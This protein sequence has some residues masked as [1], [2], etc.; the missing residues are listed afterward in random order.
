MEVEV[1]LVR[2]LKPD[3]GALTFTYRSGGALESLPAAGESWMV[4]QL[5][6]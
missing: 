1:R 3:E 2:V 5:V 4:R 6:V